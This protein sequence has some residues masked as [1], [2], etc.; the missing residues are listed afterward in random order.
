VLRGTFKLRSGA[1]SDYYID[2]YQFGTR[3]ALL[4]QVAEALAAELPE[5]TEYVAGTAL[6]AVPLAVAVSLARG[7]PSVLVRPEG[8]DHGPVR[9]VEGSLPPGARVALLEDVVTTGSAALAAVEA[10][11]EAGAKVIRVIAVVDR[12][13]GGSAA[14]EAAGVPYR[15]LLRS[16]DL[17]IGGK[18]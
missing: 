5:G 10:L 9:A 16:R 8:R 18:R 12:E 7:L 3:P 11:R 2:K 15:A 13:E 4:R 1:T 17:G 14:F 6:G